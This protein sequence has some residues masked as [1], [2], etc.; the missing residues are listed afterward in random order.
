MRKKL[1]IATIAAVGLAS[2]LSIAPFT[3]HAWDMYVWLKSGELFLHE[4]YNIYMVS[5]I[6]GFP[7]GFY[8][9]PPIWLYWLAI[10][11]FI[12]IKLGLNI[13]QQVVLIKLPII[14]S[15]II[16]GLLL[17]KLGKKYD[18]DEKTCIVLAASFILN[19][20]V[21]FI[22]SVWGMFDSIAT[23]FVMLSILLLSRRQEYLSLLSLGIGTAIKIY[24]ALFYP[25]LMVYLYK[26]KKSLKK[27]LITG[28]LLFF[29]PLLISSIP[30]LSS[31]NEYIS[32]MVFH[33]SNIG[34]FNIWTLLSPLISTELIS[35]ISMSLLFCFYVNFLLKHLKNFSSRG[36]HIRMFTAILVIFLATSLKVN[37]QYTVWLIPLLLLDIAIS[38]NRR[39]DDVVSLVIINAAGIVFV[40]AFGQLISFDI[41]S[42]GRVNIL[43]VSE[44]FIFGGIILLSAAVAGWRFILMMFNYLEFFRIKKIMI[45]KVGLSLILIVLILSLSLFPSPAG[46]ELPQSQ[47][48]IAVPESVHSIFTNGKTS[49]NNDDLD[50]IARPNIMVLSFSLDFFNLYDGYQ[51]DSSLNKYMKFRIDASDLT[52][53]KLREI[54]TN[55]K[56][57]RI[58][59]LVGVFVSPQQKY[60]S[61]GI[62]GYS[63]NW[64][65]S[66]YPEILKNGK[67]NFDEYIIINNEKTQYS[68]YLAKKISRV[69]NDF[70]FDGV[71]ILTEPDGIKTVNDVES[72]LGLLINVRREI[73]RDKILIVD[74]VDPFLS[75]DLLRIILNHTDYVVLHTSPWIDGM[76]YGARANRTVETY[77][78]CIR[79]I[80]SELKNNEWHKLLFSIYTL[81]MA[82]GWLTPALAVQLEVDSYS[83]LLDNGYAIYYVSNYL[84]YRLKLR[85]QVESFS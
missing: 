82:R 40:V 55:L 48:R 85:Q 84:P 30:Y 4:N 32:K 39:F 81:D 78:Q 9:Y 53:G 52:A 31:L 57:E 13:S 21:V 72:I 24:P 43:A 47:I 69:V 58:K 74:R 16:I 62:H 49:I 54:I 17:Y 19:P 27:L 2:R 61:Y 79:H 51:S 35:I 42:L 3:G 71:Y 83:S 28:N 34:Q 56:N 25:A 60:I 70:N 10:T 50:R 80:K 66:N 76:L 41:N 44:N 26:N 33:I 29:S 63:S 23:L 37:V 18:L 45:G 8:A 77:R 67:V 68:Y 7:W 1:L 65:L 59:V 22:S 5:D 20:L 11:Q 73:S 12:K 46:I 6:T 64:L 15:D 75:I 36:S 14:I 38:E